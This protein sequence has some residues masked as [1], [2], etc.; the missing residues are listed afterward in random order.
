MRPILQILCASTFRATP[1]D[2]ICTDHNE[3]KNKIEN[4]PHRN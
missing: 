2:R 4:I 1:V 3:F